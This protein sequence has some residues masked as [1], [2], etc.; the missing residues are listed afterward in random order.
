VLP[1]YF[2]GNTS[3]DS[4]SIAP[5][6]ISRLLIPPSLILISDLHFQQ[7]KPTHLRAGGARRGTVF[8]ITVLLVITDHQGGPTALTKT[9]NGFNLSQPSGV[10]CITQSRGWLQQKWRRTAPAVGAGGCFSSRG[11]WKEGH[12]KSKS[13]LRT[14]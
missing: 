4:N 5:R 6:P 9:P 14:G 7:T 3:Y 8:V 13:Q 10:F 12:E 11:S 1:S 2:G